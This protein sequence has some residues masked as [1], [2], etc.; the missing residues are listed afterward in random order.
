MDA[1]PSR[2]G[3]GR[4]TDRDY[5]RDPDRY[6][7]GM[8]AATRFG[9]AGA[10]LYRWIADLLDESSGERRVLRVLDL[11][12]GEGPLAAAATWRHR[13]VGVDA[14]R[15]M[16]RGARRHAPVVQGDITRLPFTRGCVDAVVAVNVLDH[17]DRPTPA[18][19]EARRVLRPKGR[20]VVGAISRTDSPELAPH[21]RPAPTPFDSEDAPEAV[22]NAGFTDV[23]VLPWDAPLVTLPDRDA[24][25]A[26]L[27]A[28]FVPPR[29]ASELA[30][31]AMLAVIAPWL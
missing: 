4:A 16:L 7:D 25:A 24:L 27:R 28:R 13:V 14:S 9:T 20:L 6:R 17:L 10:D 18:L 11:G 31:G 3:P 19:H 12:C 5:D 22:R 30:A 29:R 21:W 15:A 1:D 2:T 26:Y 8:A 23:L